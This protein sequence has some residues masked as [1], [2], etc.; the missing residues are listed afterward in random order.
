MR[1]AVYWQ[2]MNDE[3]GSIRAASLHADLALSPLGSLTPEQ[4]F[5]AGYQPK[6]IWLAV[7]DSAGIPAER[8]LGIDH[9]PPAAPF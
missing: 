4:A 9:K 5:D 1:H 8:R 6:E 3:F 2:L 7:C